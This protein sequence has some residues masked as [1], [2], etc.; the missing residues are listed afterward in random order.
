MPT[1]P[2]D[3]CASANRNGNATRRR[4]LTRTMNREVMFC[5][6]H[7][8]LSC[9]FSAFRK[10]IHQLRCERNPS[11][12]D[13]SEQ[14]LAV[15]KRYLLT[16]GSVTESKFEETKREDAKDGKPSE[17][18]Y[19]LRL[20]FFMVCRCRRWILFLL[21]QLIFQLSRHYLTM[22]HLAWLQS[23]L[24]LLHLVGNQLFQCCKRIMSLLITWEM[25][26]LFNQ[27]LFSLR[28]AHLQEVVVISYP[29]LTLWI[30]FSAKLSWN[31]HP[32]VTL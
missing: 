32:L 3:S 15:Q 25:A 21:Y 14:R 16:S 24:R 26:P 7:V 8:L 29:Y 20:M 5:Y 11:L 10:P 30:K 18:C 19:L 22:C 13:V 23:G 28:S 12:T 6:Y 17:L 1:V 9:M 31:H 27:S 4:K 2:K